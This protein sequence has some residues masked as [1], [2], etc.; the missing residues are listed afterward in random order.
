MSINRV[1]L[2]GN[3][4]RDPETRATASGNTV[5][6]F[7]IAVNER[8]KNPHTGEWDDV[9]NYVDCVSFGKRATALSNILR[10]GMK[11]SLDGKLRYH[12]WETNDGQKRSK[13]DV[14]V[15]EIEFMQARE[16]A[17]AKVQKAYPDAIIYEDDDIPF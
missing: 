6:Q 13:L 14:I 2:S 12:S 16:S 15:D 8:R 5:L 7:S 10:K 11:V 3:L 9:P 1:C 17:K 4:T